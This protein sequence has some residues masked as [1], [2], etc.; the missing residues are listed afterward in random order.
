MDVQDKRLE[1]GDQTKLRLLHIAI[2]VVAESGVRSVS[3]AK[4]AE[5]AGISKSNVFHHFKTI[6]ELL[7]ATLKQLTDAM[8]EAMRIEFQSTDHFLDQISKAILSDVK[9]QTDSFKAFLSFYHEGLFD[10][11]YAEVLDE[12]RAQMLKIIENHLRRLTTTS[13]EQNQLEA[14]SALILSVLDGI[15][16]HYLIGGNRD[17]FAKAWKFQEELLRK[18]FLT[19]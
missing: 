7:L 17:T 11:R 19:S 10:T 6:D 13:M 15:G 1:K 9:E 3:A 14:A 8:L 12:S 2:S 4:L 16:L 18:Q 5:A